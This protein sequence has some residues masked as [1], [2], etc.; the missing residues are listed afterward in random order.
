MCVQAELALS[1][2]ARE[3]SSLGQ[4]SSRLEDLQVNRGTEAYSHVKLRSALA[5]YRQ[6]RGVL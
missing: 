5:I 1:A 2:E 3:R 4:M 6:Q